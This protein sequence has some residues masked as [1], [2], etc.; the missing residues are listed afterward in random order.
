MNTKYNKDLM[1][2]IDASPVGL[3][4][5]DNMAKQFDK[6]GYFRLYEKDAWDIK[7]GGKYYVVR[8]Q[9]AIAAFCVPKKKRF[10]A[11]IMAS[12]A[13]SPMFR[14]KP[15]PEITV[16]ES[17]VKLNVEK[18]GGAILSTWFDRPL[19]IAGRILVRTGKGIESK[20]VN[21]D[22]D[23]LMI[24]SL[25]IH[26]DRETN[27][28]HKINIQ[29]EML[30]LFAQMQGKD[31]KT[32]SIKLVDEIAKAAKVKASD[33]IDSDLYLYNRQTATTYGRDGEFIA[34]GRLDDLQ[35]AFASMQ[36]LL[37]AKPKNNLAMHCVFY[38]EE[39]G[40]ETKQGA[41][42]TFLYDTL[43]RIYKACGMDE[44]DYLRALSESFMI[45]ADN[46]H[47]IHPDRT[48][49][50]DPTNRPVMNKGPVL[51]FNADQKYATDG[52][53]AALFRTICDHV[54][55]PVQTFTNRSDMPG[56]ST[57]GNISSTRVALLTADIGLAQLA[58]HSA[59]ETAGVM[60]TDYLVLTARSLYEA[61]LTRDGDDVFALTWSK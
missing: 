46:A 15:N 24:P 59:Y 13:D 39:V 41:G 36:G 17:Y 37:A 54:D 42:S 53:S 14:I 20:L 35:C 12:H 56:G 29:N 32:G 1:T 9:A 3:F 16:D 4:A 22:R 6:A 19:S 49:K 34:S 40:S 51:K 57:L 60:D 8:D 18:Y 31:G 33:I 61:A 21:I 45:S 28:G 23:L 27:E 44:E 10:S 7:P 2:F 50:A 25:A 52:V 47:S 26:M 48:D 11:M 30:P 43:H 5:I 58:M 38:N 55:V